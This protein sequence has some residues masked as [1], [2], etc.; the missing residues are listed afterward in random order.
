MTMPAFTYTHRVTTELFVKHAFLEDEETAYESSDDEATL[1]EEEC[2]SESLKALALPNLLEEI[3]DVPEDLDA[4]LD[5]YPGLFD[6][7]LDFSIDDSFDLD[8]E[9]DHDVIVKSDPSK[10][11]RLFDERL[12]ITDSDSDSD[13]DFY[14][15]L[16]DER[17]DLPDDDDFVWP[18]VRV[19]QKKTVRWADD[20]GT[21]L[22]SVCFLSS[23]NFQDEWRVFRY[24]SLLDERLDVPTDDADLDFDWTSPIVSAV[25]PFKVQC[26]RIK[27]QY[28][29]PNIRPSLFDEDPI[30]DIY[31]SEF[32]FL[33]F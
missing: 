32:D 16:L 1:F 7:R 26:E 8:F 14:P 19:A 27:G 12:A 10:F 30:F 3:L 2:G 15:D 31:D 4:D 5:F 21:N 20:Q 13:L 9:S 28:R 23:L 6:E 11:P 18:T 24:P 17:L 22:A 25:Q 33:D 29:N